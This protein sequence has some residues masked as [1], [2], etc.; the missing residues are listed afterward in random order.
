M[1]DMS[2]CAD[3]VSSGST[4]ISSTW[5]EGLFSWSFRWAV[6][7]CRVLACCLFAYD[8]GSLRSMESFYPIMR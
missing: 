5:F 6:R 8:C 1:L 3:A 2:Y 7:M 4:L